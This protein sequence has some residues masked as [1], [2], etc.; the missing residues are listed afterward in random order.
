[1]I[2]GTMALNFISRPDFIAYNIK[3]RDSLPVKLTTKLFGATKFSW[4]SR[5]QDDLDAAH[6]FGEYA[7][8]EK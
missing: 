7:I 6:G 3:D 4:T 8:F 5:S 1:M 2:L